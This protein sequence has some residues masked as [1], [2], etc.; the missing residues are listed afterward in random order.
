VFIDKFNDENKKCSCEKLISINQVSFSVA[1]THTHTHT[2]KYAP[3]PVVKF[4]YF[5]EV[6]KLFLLIMKQFKLR[7]Y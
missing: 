6:N 5:N 7:K 1:H 3:E 4:V 2:C